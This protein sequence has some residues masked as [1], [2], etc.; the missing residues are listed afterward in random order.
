ML[1]VWK[2]LIFIRKKYVWCL[3]GELV[4]FSIL[5]ILLLFRCCFQLF[6]SLI[7]L[8]LVSPH[9]FHDWTFFIWKFEA[10]WSF[11]ISI[12]L[13]RSHW[14]LVSIAYLPFWLNENIIRIPQTW[15][16][17]F[18]LIECLFFF[19]IKTFNQMHHHK[20]WQTKW[21]EKKKK[22]LKIKLCHKEEQNSYKKIYFFGW[23]WVKS[24]E[25]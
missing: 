23:Q 11:A 2:L 3:N 1:C 7:L 24:T 22:T 5:I 6:F 9:C 4:R 25:L 18:F 15:I 10:Y 13:K 19:F 21:K 20:I 12:S 16:Q 14:C 8:N 17:S